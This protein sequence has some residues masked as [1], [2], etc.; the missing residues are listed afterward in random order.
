MRWEGRLWR[1]AACGVGLLLCV[2]EAWAQTP[3]QAPFVVK[4]LFVPAG[5][6]PPTALGA[7]APVAEGLIVLTGIMVLPDGKKALLE[8]RKDPGPAK[9]TASKAWWREGET[10]GGYV[11]EAIEPAAVV[12][13]SNQQKV[14]IPLY[15]TPKERPQPMT[16]TSALARDSLK[17]DRQPAGKDA[18]PTQQGSVPGGAPPSAT[19]GQVGAPPGAGPSSPPPSGSFKQGG[20]ETSSGASQG[21]E[22]APS[23]GNPFLEALRKA[24]QGQGETSEPP[25]PG[26]ST[27]AAR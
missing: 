23:F 12:L 24:R 21:G 15:G 10:V 7:Q 3:D 18:A 17:A 1:W 27:G 4:R 19:P 25:V 5:Q 22:G 2:Q 13:A 20:P 26:A 16:T 11:L 6:L 14:R 8:M 9:E